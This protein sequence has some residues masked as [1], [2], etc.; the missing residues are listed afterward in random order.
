M[1]LKYLTLS[2]DLPK[3]QFYNKFFDNVR[4]FVSGTNLF[5]WSNFKYYD[6]GL[7]NGNDYPIMRSF[8]FGIDVKF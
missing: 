6:P 3:N 5:C 8:N 1:R 7:G 4:L 2:Y